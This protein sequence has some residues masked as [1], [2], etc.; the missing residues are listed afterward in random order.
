MILGIGAPH[1]QR[2][3]GTIAGSIAPI[4][5]MA[6]LVSNTYTGT[7]AGTSAVT[8]AMTGNIANTFTG[9]MA[10]AIVPTGSMSGTFLQNLTGTL[11]FTIA[12]TGSLTGTSDDGTSYANPGGSGNR[13]ATITMSGTANWAG[14]ANTILDGA[15]G[16]GTWFGN[17]QSGIT[18]I[19]DFGV[20]ASKTISEFK[21]YQDMATSQGTWKIAGS[22]DGLTTTD[23]ASGFTLG[24]SAT[25]TVTVGGTVG[26]RYYHL[27]QTSG[28]TSS[29]NYV[30]EIEF[31]IKD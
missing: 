10:G 23:I 25:T 11:A 15:Q 7:I 29:A 20:G 21:W 22:N 13:T 14:T 12:P 28:T 1:L 26:Y 24:S 27:I 19:F 31:K 6:G 16:N 18:I 3:T 8:G 9:T 30:R 5:T 17:G 4:G 2:F